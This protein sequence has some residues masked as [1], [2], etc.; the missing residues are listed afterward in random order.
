[1]SSNHRDGRDYNE[2]ALNSVQLAQ[3]VEAIRKELQSARA[4]NEAYMSTDYW[5]DRYQ[6]MKKAHDQ[7]RLENTDLKEWLIS[8]DE[9][10]DQLNLFIEERIGNERWMDG[11]SCDDFKL[12]D[13][14]KYW[15]TCVGRISSW[16]KRP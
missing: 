6:S 16:T 14:R 3:E 7:L 10:I 9:Q 1:M 8:K 5:F 12:G 11:R 13:L 2:P 4:E 15:V